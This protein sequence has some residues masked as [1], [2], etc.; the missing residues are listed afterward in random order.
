MCNH[1]LMKNFYIKTHGCKSN[2]LESAVITEKLIEVGY[3]KTTDIDTADIYILNSCSVTETADIE[4]LRTIRHIKSLNPQII[5][6]LTGCSAQLNFEKLKNNEYVDI[7][8]G[9]NDKFEIV[10]A[11][12]EKY[13]KVEDIF[14][15]KSFNNQLIHNY[16]NTRGYLKIQDGCNNYCSYCTIPFARGNSRSNLIKNI[17]EQIKIYTDIGI[18]EVV[19]TGIHIGQWGSDFL[20]KKELYNLLEEIEK[21]EINRYRL[22]SLNTLE[23]SDNLI[24]FLSQS[25]KFC[26]HFHLSLQS[27]TDKTLSAMNRK[28]SAQSCLDLME[29]LNKA[30]KLPF[31]GSDI[32]VGFPDESEKD[33]N[34]TIENV[35]K[36]TLSN[37]HVFPYSVRSNTK[38]A[39]MQNQI[40]LTI[41]K[42]RAKILQSIAKEKYNTFIEKNIGNTRKVLVEK[43]P[44]KKTG[45]LKAV[46]DNYLN[47]FID[48]KDKTLHNTIQKVKILY[49]KD[50]KLFCNIIE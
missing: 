1:K 39:N 44:D 31:L 19:L 18:K 43:R 21:T 26:P 10:K 42:E 32:I 11:I 36:S 8:L 23:I 7:I 37:I 46:T 5:T 28:Y 47:V 14:A 9:N 50:E 41:K 25:E 15:L 3:C 12:T 29:K 6:V 48:S 45:Q 49:R 17:L 13:S 38:A 16:S 34:M 30:F 24:E 20:E 33:F 35:K 2:Q 22:G 40:P 27:L 4:A